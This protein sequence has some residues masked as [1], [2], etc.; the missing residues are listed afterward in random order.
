MSVRA[1]A[2]AAAAASGIPS[3]CFGNNFCKNGK[4]KKNLCTHDPTTHFCGNKLVV[5]LDSFDV[6]FFHMCCGFLLSAFAFASA[7]A[8][9]AL[10][11]YSDGLGRLHCDRYREL[12]R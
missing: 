4:T 11:D 2:A 12:R 10:G 9:P 3:N 5:F 7:S 1:A 6:F 8:M